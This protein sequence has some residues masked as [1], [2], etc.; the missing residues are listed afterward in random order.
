[1]QPLRICADPPKKTFIDR[2]A[3]TILTA[4][5]AKVWKV[6]QLPLDLSSSSV[7][8]R[9]AADPGTALCGLRNEGADRRPFLHS[10]LDGSEPV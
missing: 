4:V 5:A 10:E 1:M 3:K 2:F 9:T 7:G 8:R 6:A